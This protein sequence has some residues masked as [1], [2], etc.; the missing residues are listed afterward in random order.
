MDIKKLLKHF[1][2]FASITYAAT[3]AL[4]IV[5]S[6]LFSNIENAKINIGEPIMS[7]FLYL[8]LF[9]LALALGSTIK[10]I[11]IIHPIVRGIL[12]AICFV[13]GFFGFFL[14]V[15]METDAIKNALIFSAVFALVYIIIILIA[16]LINRKRTK[17]QQ[18]P[19]KKVENNKK[20]QKNKP[21]TKQ[22]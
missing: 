5:A 16:W 21:Y 8:L 4:M 22:F 14:L 9:S 10:K 15:T 2:T 7:D 17:D 3:S 19:Q 1:I 6:L 11:D 12:H 20:S 13:G 18:P